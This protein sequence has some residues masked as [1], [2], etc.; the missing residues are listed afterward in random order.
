MLCNLLVGSVSGDKFYR[1]NQTV[2]MQC[3]CVCARARARTMLWCSRLRGLH[4]H[5]CALECHRNIS[6][7]FQYLSEVRLRFSDI[8]LCHKVIGYPTFRLVF[9][10]SGVLERFDPVTCG[11][12]SLRLQRLLFG[13]RL[14]KCNDA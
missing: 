5:I 4:I 11:N 6:S 8:T 7:N 3:V 2:R 14:H 12:S 1:G 13:E 9:K 10:G